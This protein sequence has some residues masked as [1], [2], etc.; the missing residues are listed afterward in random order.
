MHAPCYVSLSRRTFQVW[1][2]RI[3]FYR[4]L[5]YTGALAQTYAL[6]TGFLIEELLRK[7]GVLARGLAHPVIFDGAGNTSFRTFMSTFGA[8]KVMPACL[9]MQVALRRMTSAR[10]TVYIPRRLAM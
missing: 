10:L 6:D 9:Q 3:W 5:R 4:P 7:K 1:N 2:D 8:V